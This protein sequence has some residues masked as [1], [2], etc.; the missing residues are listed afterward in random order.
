MCV[1]V[2]GDY[3]VF[4]WGHFLPATSSL[5]SENDEPLE[6]LDREPGLHNTI[7]SPIDLMSL[8]CTPRLLRFIARAHARAAALSLY[9]QA[10]CIVQRGVFSAN[11]A[12]GPDG[13]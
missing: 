8:M 7:I 12:G 10:I 3:L 9:L 4:F 11:C 2:W 1:C 5:P 6:L 13:P